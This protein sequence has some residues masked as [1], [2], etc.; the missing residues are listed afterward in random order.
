MRRALG[1]AALAALAACASIEPEDPPQ[2]GANE[3]Q[4]RPGMFSGQY[5]EFVIVGDPSRPPDAIA[6]EELGAGS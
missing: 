3:M 4:V 5:G 6:E 1:L 2:M